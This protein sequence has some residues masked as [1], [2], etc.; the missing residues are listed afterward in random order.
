MT[1]MNLPPSVLE[2]SNDP[3]DRVVCPLCHTP[4]A[5]GRRAFAAGGVVR[6]SRCKQ[7]WDAARLDAVARHAER[8]AEAALRTQ[9][10]S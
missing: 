1:S 4:S 10:S 9:R 3:L 6:C 5:L 7:Q 2:E 8:V